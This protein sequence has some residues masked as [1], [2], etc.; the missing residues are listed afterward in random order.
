MHKT[1]QVGLLSLCAE[2]HS[3]TLNCTY[4]SMCNRQHNIWYE[5]TNTSADLHRLLWQSY[6]LIKGFNIQNLA[7]QNHI[8]TKLIFRTI[9]S[10]CESS[11]VTICITYTFHFR[12]YH[13]MAAINLLTKSHSE[14]QSFDSNHGIYF[15]RP[16]SYWPLSESF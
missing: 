10:E 16:R 8:L 1:E 6:Y 14:R 3:H 5:L 15:K 12:N 13:S 2:Y 4:P 7:L 11:L 9:S